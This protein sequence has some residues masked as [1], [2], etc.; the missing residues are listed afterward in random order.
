VALKKAKFYVVKRDFLGPLAT[1]AAGKLDVLWHDGHTFGMDG[2][3]V[4][5]LEQTNKVSLRGLLQ[6]H[7]GRALEAQVS[8]EVLGDLTHQ[9]LEGQLA[10]QELSALLVS[11]DLTESH[12]SR[13]VTMGLLHTSG[14]WGALTSGLGGQLFSWGLASSGL[15]SGL[16]CSCHLHFFTVN[17]RAGSS[18]LK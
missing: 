10:D 3:Q 6:S 4:G 8:L 5:V 9:T 15:T 7:D 2:T 14:S 13:P 16:L 12:S 18:K 17:D 11:T 1:D